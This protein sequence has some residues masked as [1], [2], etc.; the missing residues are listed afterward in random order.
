MAKKFTVLLVIFLVFSLSLLSGYSD[1][2]TVSSNSSSSW[3]VYYENINESAYRFDLGKNASGIE[4]HLYMNSSGDKSQSN[5]AFQGGVKF[6][7]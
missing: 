6:L 5:L 4:M 7:N 2:A 3:Y 1:R